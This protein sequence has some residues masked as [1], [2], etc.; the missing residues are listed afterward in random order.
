MWSRSGLPNA[1][2]TVQVTVL[3]TRPKGASDS[4]VYLDGF[5]AANGLHEQTRRAVREAFHRGTGRGVRAADVRHGRPRDLRR[6][7]RAAVV[8]ASFRGTGITVYAVMSSAGKAAIYIDDELRVTSTCTVPLAY[9][10]PYSSLSAHRQGPHA[11]DRRGRAPD[12]HRLGG[13]YRLRVT[14]PMA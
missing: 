5:P 11:A 4:W 8:L 13:G 6:H 2:H 7:R 9:V 10:T 3:G 1:R 14:A 12:G